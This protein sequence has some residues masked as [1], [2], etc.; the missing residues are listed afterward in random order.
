MAETD[1]LAL[2]P[3]HYL[4]L[5][6]SLGKRQEPRQPKPAPPQSSKT[7]LPAGEPRCKPSVRD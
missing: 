1:K 4:I 2:A 7:D 3:F 5:A 6:R